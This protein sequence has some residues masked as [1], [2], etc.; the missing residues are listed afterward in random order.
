MLKTL[1]SNLQ[2]LKAHQLKVM[3][4]L[5]LPKVPKC[6]CCQRSG[7]ERSLN[8]IIE[9][10]TKLCSSSTELT[11]ANWRERVLVNAGSKTLPK[12]SR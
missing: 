3:L 7:F 4:R 9:R 6:C 11:V 1:V 8:T 2:R 5:I 10:M 12:N